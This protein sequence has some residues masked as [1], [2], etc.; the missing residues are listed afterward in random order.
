MNDEEEKEYYQNEVNAQK[1]EL[2]DNLIKNLDFLFV[3]D[4]KFNDILFWLSY[5]MKYLE[6]DKTFFESDR[7]E[8]K[9]LIYF[10]HVLA[11]A[12][13]EIPI[14]QNREKFAKAYRLS[15]ELQLRNANQHMIQGQIKDL[16]DEDFK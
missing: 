1:T 6:R 16:K 11:D 2:F 10:V 15:K 12:C 9:E 5:A 8:L 13:W 14:I 7:K 3:K 4:E